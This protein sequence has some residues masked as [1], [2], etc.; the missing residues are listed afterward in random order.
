[1][2]KLDLHNRDLVGAI[3]YVDGWRSS[4]RAHRTTLTRS[5]THPG[6]NTCERGSC[7][8]T[9]FGNAHDLPRTLYVCQ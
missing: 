7:V 8:T 2:H 9:G 5:H 4:I 1:M 3:D 6:A